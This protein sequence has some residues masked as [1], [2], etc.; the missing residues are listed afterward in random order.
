MT[1]LFSALALV[2]CYASINLWNDA[3]STI[4]DARNS[5]SNCASHLEDGLSRPYKVNPLLL[6][7]AFI[8]V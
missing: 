1:Y 3:A 2:K 5:L 4:A 7:E 8:C 6:I